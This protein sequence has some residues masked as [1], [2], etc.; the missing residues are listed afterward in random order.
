LDALAKILHHKTVA[1]NLDIPKN[2]LIK[3]ILQLNKELH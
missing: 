2:L 1:I 3:S